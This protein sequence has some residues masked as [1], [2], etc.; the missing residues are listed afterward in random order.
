MTTMSTIKTTASSPPRRRHHSRHHRKGAL[1]VLLRLVAP[2]TLCLAQPLLAAELPTDL[3]QRL[4]TGYIQPAV[5]ELH[6][7]GEKLSA[8]LPA[9]CQAPGDSAHREAVDARFRDLVA[10]WGRVELLRFGPLL[11]RNRLER[12]FFFPDT[13]GVTQRQL[14]A[15]LAVA[16]PAALDAGQLAKRSVAVQGIP[17]LDYLLYNSG[18]S[19]QIASDEASG[20]Y[21]CQLAAA[22]ARNLVA[23][24]AEL[25]QAWA[26]DTAFARQFVAPGPQQ[27]VYRSVGEVGTEALKML[28]T[29]LQ[30]TRDIKLLP[31]VGATID[32]A[33]GQ[34]AP[35][36]R[37]QLTVELLQANVRG[38]LDIYQATGFDAQLPAEERWIGENLVAEG[39][40]LLALLEEPLPPFERAVSEAESREQLLYAIML[41]KNLQAIVVEYLPPA[42][43]VNIGFNSLDGD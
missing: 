3:G 32:S 15:L 8:A 7:T 12:L 10:A 43:G 13:R 14:S 6:R 33:R 9:Y 23:V 26:G 18:A 11:E 28:S 40:R 34:R 37:S 39:E 20:R 1:N 2:L 41:L 35:L 25:Q 24:S 17:A 19:E 4:L 5:A 30:L 42:F 36:W 22:S 29:G 38:L 27:P 21:R 16:D 31:A